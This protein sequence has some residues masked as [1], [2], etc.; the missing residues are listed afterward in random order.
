MLDLKN[1]IAPKS[2]SKTILETLHTGEPK[3]LRKKLTSAQHLV[4]MCP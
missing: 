2:E 4:L 1:A 3:C